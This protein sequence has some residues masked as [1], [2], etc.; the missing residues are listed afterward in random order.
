[1][2]LSIIF[3]ACANSEMLL[4]L[5]HFVLS[6]L[7]NTSK[8]AFSRSCGTSHS[9]PNADD[10]VEQSLSQGEITVEG[11]VEQLDGNLVPSNS[12][13]VAQERMVAI[14]SCLVG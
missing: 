14:N 4:A 7:R 8:V 6:L 13:S 12:L 2:I 3:P 1:M 5:S 9:P 11:D 10:D